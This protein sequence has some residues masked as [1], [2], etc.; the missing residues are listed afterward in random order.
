MSIIRQDPH[1]AFLD[2]SGPE[3]PAGSGALDG[4]RLAV[5]DIYDVAGYRTGCGN[6]QKLA[7][8]QPAKA[9]APSVQ[10]LIDAGAV[11]VGKT[12]TDELAFS[13]TGDNAHYPRPINPAAPD[14]VAG[15]S[16]SGSA[17]AVTAALADIGIGS[18]TGGS[19][20]APA[21]YCG[22]VGLR[23]SHGVISLDGAMPL[24]PSLDTFGWFAADMSLYTRVAGV[25]L[26]E[27]A[28]D[29][30]HAIRLPE[31]EELLLGE[32]E[33]QAFAES[34]SMVEAVLGDARPVTLTSERDDRYWCLRKIQAY[35]AWKVHGEW[36]RAGD[37]QLGPGVK[38]RFDFG[39]GVSAEMLQGETI[40]REAIT[41]DASH[42]IGEDGVF[43][44]P[45][46]PGAAPLAAASF[47][48]IQAY[49]ERAITLLCVSGLTGLPELTL[50]LGKVDGAP[51]GLSLIGPK[52]SD[53]A[54]LAL[55]ETILA[56]R[57]GEEL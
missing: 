54:L 21:S 56:A 28:F 9:T 38:E 34:L 25:L 5:K 17:V 22:L 50:P 4:S 3:I 52:G 11:F 43:V 31:Q 39:S 49:R 27:A 30:R 44:T 14:R 35:E 53:R 57:E 2:L 32:S 29:L 51:F 26:P 20:R 36:I 12:Q 55:G 13:L 18:D 41:R 24:A 7:E 46:V 8:S 47:E 37:R 40:V 33:R 15:G 23:T 42:L 16:S 1:N 19:I 45:T 6:P 10:A 48:E